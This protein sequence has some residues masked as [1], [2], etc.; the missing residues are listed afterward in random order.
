MTS[1]SVVPL[2]KPEQKTSKKPRAKTSGKAQ[3]T[4][5]KTQYARS[6]EKRKEIASTIAQKIKE[7][8]EKTKNKIEEIKKTKNKKHY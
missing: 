6:A 1:F 2:G 7:E 5:R 8:I 3:P 4:K